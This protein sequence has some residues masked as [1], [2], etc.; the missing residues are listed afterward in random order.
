MDGAGCDEPEA[1]R[2]NGERDA[3]GSAAPKNRSKV[4]SAPSCVYP[5]CGSERRGRRGTR[6]DVPV[7]ALVGTADV[8]VGGE[9]SA[10]TLQK[11]PT[12][13]RRSR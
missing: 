11:M 2:R 13:K 8:V 3:A 7:K 1:G 5:Y 9:G 6:V 4:W 10:N 12:P